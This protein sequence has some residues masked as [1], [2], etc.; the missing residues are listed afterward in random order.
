M[1]TLS[2]GWLMA[3]SWLAADSLLS[4]RQGDEEFLTAKKA[5]AAF[6]LNQLLPRTAGLEPAVTGGSEPLYEAV[7]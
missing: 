1:G 5:T 7:L 4:S 2:G 3:R 6:Y